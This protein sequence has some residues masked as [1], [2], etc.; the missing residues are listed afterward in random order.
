MEFNSFTYILFLMLSAGVFWSLKSVKKRMLLVFILSLTFYSFWSV[1]FTLLL[2]IFTI[3]CYELAKIIDKSEKYRRFSLVL[4]LIVSLLPLLY[5]KYADFILTNVYG[6]FYFLDFE[7]DKVFINAI[8]PIGISFYTFQGVSYLIDVYRRRE[9]PIDSYIIFANYIIFWPQMI[10]GPIIRSSEI[11]GQFLVLKAFKHDF[12]NRGLFFITT[13]LLLKVL[14]AD[15]I[16]PM[17]NDGFDISPDKLNFFDAWTLA[18]AFG[19]QIYF[20]FA[21]YSMIAIGSAYL[22]G[23]SL[24]HNFLFPY[25]SKNVRE[26]WKRWHITLSSWIRDYLYIP[27][28]GNKFS[29]DK[30]ASGIEIK[31]GSAFSALILTWSIMGFWHGASWN[32]LFWGL[33]QV[34]LVLIYRAYKSKIDFVLPSFISWSFTIVFVMAG[35]IFFRADNLSDAFII[36]STMFDILNVDL[37]LGLRENFYLITFLYLVGIIFFY[38]IHRNLNVIR[39]SLIFKYV[40]GVYMIFAL[41]ILLVELKQVEQFIYFQF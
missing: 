19:F 36:L 16:A 40:Y 34:L 33:Y 35:W 29:K 2:I 1:N 30:S 24:P 14:F 21:G 13:G 39:K 28:T 26:F 7:I 5:F 15:N 31:D 17:V 41:T 4:S 6:L 9:K 10:A 18:F 11:V 12:I 37:S 22:F 27:L 3:S 20:D 23:I 8:L 32:F 25:M 38:Q